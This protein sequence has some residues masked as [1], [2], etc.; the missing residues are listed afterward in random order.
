MKA[1][2]RGSRQIENSGRMGLLE[3]TGDNILCHM[4]AGPLQREVAVK[5]S[6]QLF[7]P[8]QGVMAV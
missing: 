4:I 7:N 6:A 8:V 3:N 2:I 1:I 5:I